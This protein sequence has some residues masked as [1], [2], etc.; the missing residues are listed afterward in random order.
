MVSACSDF[1]ALRKEVKYRYKILSITYYKLYEC[2][3]PPI[4]KT[5]LRSPILFVALSVS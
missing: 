1:S 2:F 5:F 3:S 4:K